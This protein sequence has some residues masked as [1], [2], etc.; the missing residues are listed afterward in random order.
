MKKKIEEKDF[1]TSE[2]MKEMFAGKESFWDSIKYC[3]SLVN[4]YHKYSF[5]QSK[6]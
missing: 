4:K 6:K 2:E 1:Y 3:L 5:C